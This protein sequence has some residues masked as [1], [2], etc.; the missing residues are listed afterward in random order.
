MLENHLV[1]IELQMDDFYG[2]I[3]EEELDC[4]EDQ[5]EELIH[6]LQQVYDIDFDYETECGMIYLIPLV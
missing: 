3:E 5:I 1:A 2:W 4:P 6:Q